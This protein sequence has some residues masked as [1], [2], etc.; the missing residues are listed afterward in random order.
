MDVSSYGLLSTISP[1][2]FSATMSVFDSTFL[3]GGVIAY[4]VFAVK[5]GIHSTAGTASVTF[6]VGALEPLNMVVV[7]LNSTFFIEWNNPTSRF[8]NNYNVY[9]DANPVLGS[10]LRANATLIYAGKNTNYMH[11]ISGAEMDEYHQFW[12]EITTL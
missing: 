11:N 1:Q 4:R 2:D 10:L 6:T 5:S 9:K 8:V 3:S 12:V 7:P